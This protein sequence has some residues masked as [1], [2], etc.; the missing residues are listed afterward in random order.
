MSINLKDLIKS[1]TNLIHDYQ[2][3]DKSL[4]T[5]KEK[6]KVEG[7]VEVLQFVLHDLI[8]HEEGKVI[9]SAANVT[10]EARQ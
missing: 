3:D 5:T 9:D 1:Y 2:N 10:E 7:R 4:L 8:M 6:G